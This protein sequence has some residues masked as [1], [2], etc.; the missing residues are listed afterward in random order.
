MARFDF[1]FMELLFKMVSGQTGSISRVDYFPQKKPG[2]FAPEASPLPRATPES[3][4]ISSAYLADYLKAL[5]ADPAINPHHAMVL[6][7]GKVIAEC[8]FSP[9]RDNLWHITHSMCKSITGMAIGLLVSEGKLS[10]DEKV[11]DIFARYFMPFNVLTAFKLR[12]LTVRHLLNMTSRAVFYESGAISGNDWRRSYLEAGVKDTPG[13]TFE[14]NSMNSYMLSAIV[15]EKTG[16]S[17]FDYLKPRLFAPLGITEIFWEACPQGITK[18][19]WGLFLRP[20]DAAKFGQLYLQK[21]CWN[22][23]QLIPREWVEA[24]CSKQADTG[25]GKPGYGYQ[26]WMEYRPGSFAFNG[27]L[28]QDVVVYPDLDMVI[29]INAGNNEM[30][31]DGAMT[32]L[33]R[34]TFGVGY[35][36]A[37]LLP[38]NPSALGGLQS[39]IRRLEGTDV[40]LSPVLQGGWPSKRRKLLLP[41]GW[42]PESLTDMAA[43]RIYQMEETK[44][45]IFPI[46]MQVFHNNF[47]DGIRQIEFRKEN[48]R[49]SVVFT[50][51][52]E[53][54]VITVG[55]HAPEISEILMHNEPYLVGTTGTVS[56]DETGRPV[57]MLSI[58]Y[59]EETCARKIFFYFSG[60]EIEVRFW[61]VPGEEVLMTGLRF[62]E[63]SSAKIP[64][65]LQSV[66]GSGKGIVVQSV[67]S[68]IH[69][70][71]EGK[72]G[73]TKE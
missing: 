27:M 8:S 56:R 3:Q 11:A 61:E 71:C 73:E 70:V 58:D 55:F 10:L 34:R 2:S 46:L 22:G 28:G 16:M 48:G 52:E 24:S 68:A 32:S 51:G 53:K 63:E 57:L 65:I 5:K 23:V 44:A 54:H 67:R 66:I 1:P 29:T 33:M 12:D 42:T 9:Y 15:T 26:I 41:A 38:E 47:T 6:R 14:Y 59:L 45:G 36:P 20:E 43:G 17:M 37:D 7:H 25:E 62:V 35:A 72:M 39:T 18:G 13:S 64:G 30:L 49:F 50:E 4:G 21:G 69:P 31:Q 60:N 40:C 19:G